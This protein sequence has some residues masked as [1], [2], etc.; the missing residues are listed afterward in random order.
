MTTVI[1]YSAPAGMIGG[2][3]PA[4]GAYLETFDVDAFGGR[5]YATWT[6]DPKQAM[7]FPDAGAAFAAWKSQSRTRPLRPDGKPNR[8]LTAY[9]VTVEPAP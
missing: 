2:D 3:L 6:T 4:E 8:P 7:R 9:T 1:R 5:G